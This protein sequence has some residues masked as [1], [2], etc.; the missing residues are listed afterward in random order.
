VETIS[1]EFETKLNTKPKNQVGGRRTRKNNK[2][3]QSYVSISSI[4][5]AEFWP[6]K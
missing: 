3:S 2:G 5:D 6:S 4:L 1:L